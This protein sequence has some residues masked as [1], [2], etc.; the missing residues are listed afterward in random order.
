VS[1][2][3]SWVIQTEDLQIGT[4]LSFDLTD[5]SGQVLHKAGMPINE[6]LKERLKKKNIHSVTVRGEAQ[7]D[8]AKAESVL[9]GSYPA[10]TIEAI[11]ES[12][13][14][15]Q[16]A[17]VS[18]V[19]SLKVNPEGNA[20]QVKKSV[21]EF[22]QQANKD[23]SATLAVL[24]LRSKTP[25]PAIAE[26]IAKQSTKISLLGVVISIIREVDPNDSFEIGVAG[27]L[28]DV[29]LMNHPEWFEKKAFVKVEAMLEEY[30]RH[31]IESAELLNGIGGLPKNVITIITQ[32]HEQ[33][34]GTGYPRGLKLKQTLPDAT[35]LNLTD[36]YLTLT[37]PI[38]GTP[39]VAADALA[40]LCFQT[41]QGKFC[42]SALQSMLQSM[43]VY[44]IGSTVLLDDKS[45]AVVIQGC[46]SSP[47]TPIVRLLDREKNRIDLQESNQHIVGP[48]IASDAGTIMRIKK[49]QMQN[50]LWRTDI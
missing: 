11:Q 6:R 16:L 18:L 44:P 28:H 41:A 9:L 30:R 34:D 2:D 29:S 4:S 7:S 14:N 5:A 12:I 42:K 23:L 27:L 33:A 31:P 8:I 25:N 40:Y 21:N 45:T 46:D 24:A 17:V 1:G 19:E 36:A 13:S 10:S 37:E 35:I 47:L 3:Q 22:V 43:S 39:M 26:R 38:L 32:V 50:V 49:S 15:A 48:Y 20:D